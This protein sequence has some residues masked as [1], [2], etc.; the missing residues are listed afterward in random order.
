MRAG[1]ATIIL[2]FCN[3]FCAVAIPA[4]V[5]GVARFN[6]TFNR[7]NVHK[8]PLRTFLNNIPKVEMGYRLF[9]L[10]GSALIFYGIWTDPNTIK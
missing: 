4:L 5:R 7:S 8:E 6:T 2:L 1:V 3:F 9:F 10:F